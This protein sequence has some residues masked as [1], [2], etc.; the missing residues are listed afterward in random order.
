MT[1][2][3]LQYFIS[4]WLL[5]C[6]SSV[7][8]GCGKDKEQKSPLPKYTVLDEEIYD[9]PVKA[10]VAIYLLVSKDISKEG[11]TALLKHLYE[12]NRQRGGFKYHKHPTN[13][14]IY[15]YHSKE[16]AEEMGQ[17]VGMLAKTRSN[18]EPKIT[19]D[20]EFLTQLKKKPEVKFGLTETKRRL[21]FVEMIAVEVRANEEA[22][23]KYPEQIMREASFQNELED[24]YNNE[25]CTKYSLTRDQ[26]D[27]IGLEGVVNKWLKY[28]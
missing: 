5:V 28:E 2:K 16:H 11:L 14:F 12:K 18:S 8:L 21:I 15:A 3:K 20:E 1:K 13:I 6:L 23:R 24:K 26:F 22:H 4:V 9:A 25:L 19:I 27:A 17:W 10:Q 7:L